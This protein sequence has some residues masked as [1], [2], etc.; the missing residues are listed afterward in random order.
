MPAPLLPLLLR[1]LLSRLLLPAAR[2]ARQ[3]LL[4]LLRRLARRLGSQ[5]LREA[6]LSCLLFI[7]SQRHQP[8]TG[9]A[10]RVARPERRERLAP[11]K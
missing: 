8:D 9:E 1:M 6:L 11:Q 7:L 2:L 4:P 5:D 3:H 10:S